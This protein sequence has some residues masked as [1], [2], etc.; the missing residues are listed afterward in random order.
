MLGQSTK[1]T[2]IA[3]VVVAAAVCFYLLSYLPSKNAAEIALRNKENC[4]KD[5]MAWL[6]KDR[7]NSN[8]LYFNIYGT[9]FNFKLQTCLV[10]FARAEQPIGYHQP[11]YDK[12]EVHDIYENQ[13]LLLIKD[14]SST[15]EREQQALMTE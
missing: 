2:S 8:S 4:A 14:A 3:T 13:T 12:Y 5:G 11:P 1:F 10:S 15:F 6:E 7:A 9:H